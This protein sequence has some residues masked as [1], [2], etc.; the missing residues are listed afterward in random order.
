MNRPLL[1]FIAASVLASALGTTPHEYDKYGG[2]YGLKGEKTGFL[3]TQQINGRWWLVTPEGNAFISKGVAG[4]YVGM[5]EPG[6]RTVSAAPAGWTAATA[7]QL[8]GE[9]FN[10][11]GTGSDQAMFSAEMAYTFILDAAESAKRQPCAN[12][13]VPDCIPVP[14]YFTDYFSEEFR[15][16]TDALARKLCALRANDPWL[17][18]YDYAQALAALRGRNVSALGHALGRRTEKTLHTRR[19]H[20]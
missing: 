13:A 5:E 14:G 11:I 9:G 6:V 15:K 12:A 19:Q 7:Q 20:S 17:A 18:G 10:T 3:H 8:K 4:V 16:S 2:W 1:V